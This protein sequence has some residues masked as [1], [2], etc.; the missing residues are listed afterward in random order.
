MLPIDHPRTSGWP[1]WRLVI[2][3]LVWFAIAS[4]VSGGGS[5][6]VRPTPALSK[7]TTRKWVARSSMNRGSQTSIVPAY[8]MINT[9]DGPLPRTRYATVPSFVGAVRTGTEM[10]ETGAAEG[11][12]EDEP[13]PLSAAAL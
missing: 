1:R 3:A 8:P 12:V 9:S 7:I 13:H 11:G 5:G 2:S 6:C 10:I 4:I